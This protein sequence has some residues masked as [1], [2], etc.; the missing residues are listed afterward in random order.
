MNIVNQD[1]IL[2]YINSKSIDT[3]PKT[4]L[5]EGKSGSG[6][7]TIAKYIADKFNLIINDISECITLDTINEAYLK[8][9][10]YLYIIDC[11]KLSNKNENTLLKFLEEPLKNS[12]IILITEN[13]YSLINTIVNRCFLITLKPYSKECLKS[14]ITNTEYT[15]E[16]LGICETPGDVITL[17]NYDISALFDFCIKIFDKIHIAS[18]ANTLSISD[19]IAFKSEKD[20]YDVNIFWRILLKVSYVRVVNNLPNSIKQYEL[21]NKFFNRLVI[22]NI[23]KKYLLEQYLINLKQMV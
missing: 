6:R 9:E 23:D 14:F 7:H 19:K 21:T 18:Y 22:R 3:L 5:L 16:I 8:I 1:R 17:Q 13:K 15:D 2:D 11:N 4:I 10:P 12:F 20:K